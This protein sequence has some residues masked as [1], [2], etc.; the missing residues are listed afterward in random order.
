LSRHADGHGGPA[1]AEG[2]DVARLDAV[3]EV[4]FVIL[5]VERVLSPCSGHRV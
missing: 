5:G 4:A 1:A 3:E 2:T